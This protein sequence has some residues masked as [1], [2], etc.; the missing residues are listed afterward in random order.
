MQGEWGLG[1]AAS[2]LLTWG[3]TA[4]LAG[5]FRDSLASLARG[6][7]PTPS[8]SVWGSAGNRALDRRRGSPLTETTTTQPRHGRVR[9]CRNGELYHFLFNEGLPNDGTGLLRYVFSFKIS[10]FMQ[11]AQAKQEKANRQKHVPD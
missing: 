9:G 3:S 4:L 1:L 8:P 6:G 5:R 11:C 10:N 7:F 2:Q